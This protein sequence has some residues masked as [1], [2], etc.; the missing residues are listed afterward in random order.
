MLFTKTRS[1]YFKSSGP[2]FHNRVVEERVIEEQEFNLLEQNNQRVIYNPSSNEILFGYNL[3]EIDKV[4]FVK[5]YELLP[6]ADGFTVN[7]YPRR[8]HPLGRI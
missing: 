1:N 7:D 8:R 4:I 3:N 2:N 5:G 6:G